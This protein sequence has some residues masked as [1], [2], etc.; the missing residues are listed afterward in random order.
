MIQA[1]DG[2]KISESDVEYSRAEE[3][4]HDLP[5]QGQE[6][7]P[8]EEIMGAM[9]SIYRS[10]MTNITGGNAEEWR[11]VSVEPQTID[12]GARDNVDDGQQAF[13]YYHAA[14]GRSEWVL[15]NSA[16]CNEHDPALLDDEEMA[17]AHD[18]AVSQVATE[19]VK[20]I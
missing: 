7:H 10:N 11:Q 4:E 18:N 20:Y 1:A 2:S 9:L 17:A 19:R 13:Y 15:P 3:T 14:S 5:G 12:Y 16:Y 6:W 8:N